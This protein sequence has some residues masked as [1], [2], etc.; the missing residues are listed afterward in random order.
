MPRREHGQTVNQTDLFHSASVTAEG[1]FE[2]IV[3]T[4][5][6][7]YARLVLWHYGC[8]KSVCSRNT[9]VIDKYKHN[10]GIKYSCI[11]YNF[12]HGLNSQHCP[13]YM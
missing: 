5:T 6:S 3:L 7:V 13:L 2:L 9:S 8:F 11:M 12:L 1:A 10:S 4:V